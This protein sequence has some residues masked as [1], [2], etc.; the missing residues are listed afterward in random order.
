MWTFGDLQYRYDKVNRRAD[1]CRSRWIATASRSTSTVALPPRWWWTDLRFRQSSVE[2]RPYFE[3]RPLT[4]EEKRKHGLNPD[5]FA[6]QVKYVAEFAKIVKSHELKV[7]DIIA[8]VDG[9]ERDEFA[10]TAELYIKL[11]KSAGDSVTLDVHPRR[12]AAEDA[13]QDLQD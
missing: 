6:S 8:A 4:E 7:G 9:V 1:S 13:A 5:G 2:P 10:N 12:Q 11:H 3:D